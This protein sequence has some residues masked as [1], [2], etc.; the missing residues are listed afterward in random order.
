M[1]V[2]L[3]AAVAVA[4]FECIVFSMRG[5]LAQALSSHASEEKGAQKHALASLHGSGADRLTVFVVRVVLV[6]S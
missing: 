4:V 2:V 3:V 1:V 5:H 6:G